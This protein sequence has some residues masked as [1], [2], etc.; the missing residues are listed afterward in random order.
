MGKGGPENQHSALEGI[1]YHFLLVP[2]LG[3]SEV[4]NR[5][6]F[7]LWTLKEISVNPGSAQ[8]A[9]VNMLFY[10]VSSWFSSTKLSVL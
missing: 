2:P 8:L 4:N 9:S 3:R 5:L 6:E 7:D 1:W 10:T